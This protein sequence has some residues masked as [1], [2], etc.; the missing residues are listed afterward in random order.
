MDK[1]KSD[2]HVH[3]DFNINKQ[4]VKNVL[5]LAEKNGVKASY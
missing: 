4:A 1:V 3:L 5:S 2:L